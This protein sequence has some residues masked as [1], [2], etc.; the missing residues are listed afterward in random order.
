MIH[1]GAASIFSDKIDHYFCQEIK[2]SVSFLVEMNDL[3]LFYMHP[4]WFVPRQLAKR[5][6]AGIP[7]SK[8]DLNASVMVSL[9]DP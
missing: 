3:N 2:T 5:T 4:K 9:T 1:C 7:S 6:P 8:K